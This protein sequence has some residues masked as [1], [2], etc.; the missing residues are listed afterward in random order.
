MFCYAQD[1]K[2]TASQNI[3]TDLRQTV[4]FDGKTVVEKNPLWQSVYQKP[5]FPLLFVG[6]QC[7]TAAILDKQKNKDTLYA[8][9]SL[10]QIGLVWNNRN[11]TGYGVPVLSFRF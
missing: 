4:S 5:E 8:I 6:Y 10:V 3:L 11:L 2:L 1:W 9:W 7:A